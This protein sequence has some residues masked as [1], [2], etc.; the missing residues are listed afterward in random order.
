MF[1]LIDLNAIF[2]NY[3]GVAKMLT[4]FRT[5]KKLK[6]VVFSMAGLNR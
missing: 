4:Y 2:A 6:K 5:K 3:Q 1:F